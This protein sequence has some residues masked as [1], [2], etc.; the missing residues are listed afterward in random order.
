MTRKEGNQGKSLGC[1]HSGRGRVSGHSK[2]F[3]GKVCPRQRESKCRQACVLG[4]VC[5]LVPSHKERRG[6][7]KERD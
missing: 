4:P 2:Q 3:V 7:K 1:V 5:R 6:G